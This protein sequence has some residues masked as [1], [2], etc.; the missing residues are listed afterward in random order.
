MELRPGERILDEAK[1]V[2]ANQARSQHCKGKAKAAY[3]DNLDT[4]HEIKKKQE[5]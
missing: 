1:F 5:K 2:A 4:Y 3:Q